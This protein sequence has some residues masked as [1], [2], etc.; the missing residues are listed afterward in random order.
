[1]V[2]LYKGVLLGCLKND[3]MTFVGNWVG[4][5]KEIIL[6]V[7][8]QTQKDDYGMDLLICGY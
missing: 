2:Y 7:V 4:L 5:E 1:M 3:I 6:N 8:F